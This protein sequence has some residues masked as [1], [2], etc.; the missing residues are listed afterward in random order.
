LAGS[1]LNLSAS[2]PESLFKDVPRNPRYTVE[3]REITITEAVFGYNNFYEF[4][5]DKRVSNTRPTR[6]FEFSPARRARTSVT[7]ALLE[8]KIATT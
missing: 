3:D 1:Q 4:S 8:E 6:C 5:L 2:L 7:T